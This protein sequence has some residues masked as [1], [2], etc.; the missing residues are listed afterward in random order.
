MKSIYQMIVMW[1]NDINIKQLNFV[2]QY[3]NDKINIWLIFVFTD[4]CAFADACGINAKCTT[5]HH[6]KICTCPSPLL[7]DPH[8][9]CKQEFLPCSSELECLPGQ[10]CYSRSCYTACRRW[11]YFQY[12]RIIMDYHHQYSIIYWNN[13]IA[14]LAIQT[15][16]AMNDVTAVS[17]RQY[18]TVTITVLEIRFVIIV[19][20]ILDVVAIIHVLV[21]NHVLIISAEVSTIIYSMQLIFIFFAINIRLKIIYE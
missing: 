19:C 16:W 8:S 20:A 10:T 7:G 6:Q 3:E 5:V 21:M 9:G 1:E 4:P 2:V 13:H 18:V 17:A 14:L 11:E 12:E 15:V